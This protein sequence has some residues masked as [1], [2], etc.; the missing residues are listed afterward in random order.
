[1]L[2]RK[3]IERLAVFR[4][5]G[6]CSNLETMKFGILLYLKVPSVLSEEECS[7]GGSG[8]YNGSEV[9]DASRNLAS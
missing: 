8:E 6:L 9:F 4:W 7:W 1:M 2:P 3:A 5:C